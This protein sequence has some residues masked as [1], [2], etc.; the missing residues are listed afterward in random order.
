MKTSLIIALPPSNLRI[1]LIEA[2]GITV[3]PSTQE[4]RDQIGSDTIKFVSPDCIYPDQMQKGIRSLLKTFGFHPSGRSRPASEFLFKDLQNRGGFNFIN[5]VVDI[6]NHLSLTSHLP[7]STFDLEKS[8]YDLCLRIGLDDETYIFNREGQEL[9]LKKLLVVARHGMDSAAIGSPVKDSQG[10]K[11]FEESKNIA[12]VI[13][14]SGNVTTED[15][16]QRLLD[17]YV[18]L[19]KKE[20]GAAEIESAILNAAP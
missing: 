14:T 13:Y 7:I 8:G 11:V 16:M 20:T 12:V 9:S 6:N 15:D 2:R 3:K 10:T 1:G 4:Y 17:R 19:L 18:R 5:N